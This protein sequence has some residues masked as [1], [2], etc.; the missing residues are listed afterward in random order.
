M[1][2]ADL[3][4]SLLL[5]TFSFGDA[6]FAVDAL[7]VQEIIRVA[8]ITPVHHAPDHVLGIINLRGRI[9]T[10]LDPGRR[11][12]LGNQEIGEA[13]RILI[14]D[15]QGEQ[16]GLLVT[17]VQDVIRADRDS[18]TTPPPN[19]RAMLGAFA[20]KVVQVQGHMVSILDL[21]ALL[22][23]DDAAGMA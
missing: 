8:A 17:R 20:R 1:S 13:S 6:F 2:T 21:D 3:D 16:V 10:V 14:L 4:S 18:L 12:E 15:W 22:A 7:Q 5:A 9:V 23:T 19:L 11:L